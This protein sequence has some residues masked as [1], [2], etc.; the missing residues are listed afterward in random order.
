MIGQ[1]RRFG[2][3]PLSV[4]AHRVAKE[5]FRSV[6]FVSFVRKPALVGCI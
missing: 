4:R 1:K 6:F 2:V 3:L 5:E